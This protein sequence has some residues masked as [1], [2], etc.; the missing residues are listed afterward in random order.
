MRSD[1][2]SWIITTEVTLLFD[3]VVVLGTP[4]KQPR[5]PEPILVRVAALSDTNWLERKLSQMQGRALQWQNGRSITLRYF[6]YFDLSIVSKYVDEVL[7]SGDN[8]DRYD[9]S[10]ILEGLLETVKVPVFGSAPQNW[11]KLSEFL[12]NGGV[13]GTGIAVGI[14]AE[15]WPTLV[16]SA[17]GAT[18]F[19]NIIVPASVGIGRG[20][21]RGLEYR[22]DQLLGTPPESPQPPDEPESPNGT[23]A[24]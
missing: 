10:D 17:I 23:P 15:S 3:D 13:T 24:S 14:G 20:L 18:L 6:D 11:E 9:S 1:D 12:V 2:S 4:P 22:I 7:E 16:A 5:N 19:I 21:K 8:E